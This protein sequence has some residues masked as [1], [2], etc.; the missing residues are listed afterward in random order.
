MQSTK[1]TTLAFK[2]YVLPAKCGRY[3]R[4]ISILVVDAVVG[5]LVVYVI[6][7]PPFKDFQWG[8]LASPLSGTY[9]LIGPDKEIL[10]ALS[11]NYYLTTC[12][13]GA[14]KN[15]LIETVLLSTHKIC[16]G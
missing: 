7:P 15:R 6:M 13:L 5:V 8:Q 10:F 14:Q 9:I 4:I 11:F 3:I 12:V 16:F 2:R 1:I